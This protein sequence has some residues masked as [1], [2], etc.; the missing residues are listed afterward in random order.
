MSVIARI[1]HAL[2]NYAPEYPS[3]PDEYA[4]G[5]VDGYMAA[6]RDALEAIAVTVSDGFGGQWLKCDRDDC[7]LKVVRPGKVQCHGG[8]SPVR[9]EVAS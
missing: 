2:D 8:C 6:R 7:D 5:F 3:D 1:F 4:E 9:H